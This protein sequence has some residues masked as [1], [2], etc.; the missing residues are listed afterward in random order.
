MK[1]LQ[2]SKKPGAAPFNPNAGDYDPESRKLR[3][4]LAALQFPNESR[5]FRWVRPD[6]AWEAESANRF[7]GLEI[8]NARTIDADEAV[9]RI[10]ARLRSG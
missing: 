3:V 7:D 6:L 2:E 5:E 9:R 4:D 10:D 1:D 8:G